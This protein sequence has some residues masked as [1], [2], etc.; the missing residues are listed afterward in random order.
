MSPATPFELYLHEHDDRS[1]HRTAD[2]LDAET[3]LVDRAA[4]RVCLSFFP[5]A[6]SGLP[7]RAT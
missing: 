7:P 6:L 1:W 5:M 3:H 4:A 2:L